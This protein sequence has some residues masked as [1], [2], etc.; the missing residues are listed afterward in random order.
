MKRYLKAIIAVAVIS[1]LCACSSK[2]D[3]KT[4]SN[5][6]NTYLDSIKS[7]DFDKALGVTDL[8]STD[9]ALSKYSALADDA[10]DKISSK[11]ADKSPLISEDIVKAV[12]KNLA[13]EF[14]DTIDYTINSTTQTSDGAKVNVTV[15][16]P[17]ITQVSDEDARAIL[18][19]VYDAMGIDSTADLVEMLLDP[20][21]E[22]DISTDSIKEAFEG[23]GVS[24]YARLL[25]KA[26][27][28]SKA[29]SSILSD[30]PLT[31]KN[32]DFY[33]HQDENGEWKIYDIAD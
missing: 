31:S 3:E 13:S 27:E 2:T 15:S 20:S 1:V 32:L 7:S 11:I 23:M 9:T 10:I 30:L 18:G 5:T 19:D 22:L 26:K 16:V 8:S 17:D 14:T 29:S 33:L 24:D 28:I 6:V 21:S 12:T 4:A 25:K